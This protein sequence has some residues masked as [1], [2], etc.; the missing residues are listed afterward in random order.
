MESTDDNPDVVRQ[1]DSA[2][3]MEY[4]RLHD[5]GTRHA[6][7]QAK[8]KCLRTD[9]VRRA[10]QIAGQE[11]SRHNDNVLE[12]IHLLAALL[13]LEKCFSTAMLRH[14]HTDIPSLLTKV[15]CAYSCLADSPGVCWVG[16]LPKSDRWR[17]VF[18]EAE[19]KATTA[20]SNWVGSHHL[21]I[22][23][24]GTNGGL[25]AEVLTQ[26]GLSEGVL[27]NHVWVVREMA[28]PEGDTALRS[29]DA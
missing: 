10:M 5:L 28:C 18:D 26:N 21:L 3:T 20:G 4:A 29:K 24:S 9:A 27:L 8:T 16:P 11:G 12:P 22:A 19:A 7:W 14:L 25:A 13:Q 6:E 2:T 17:D 1:Q 15:R 23:L